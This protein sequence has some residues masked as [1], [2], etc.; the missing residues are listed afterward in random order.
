LPKERA[1]GITQMQHGNTAIW[2]SPTPAGERPEFGTTIIPDHPGYLAPSPGALHREFE[3]ALAE[4]ERGRGREPRRSGYAGQSQEAVFEAGL[5]ALTS[6]LRAIFQEFHRDNPDAISFP[7]EIIPEM[8]VVASSPGS[9]K[10]TSAKAFML[11]VV[12]EGLEDKYPLG[13]AFVVQHVETAA[14]AYEELKPLLPG[15]VAVWTLEHDADSPVT[16]REPRFTVSELQDYP[17]IIVT[18]EF[19]KGVRAEKARSYRRKGMS[20]P[21]VVTFVDEKVEQVRV[22]DIKFSDIVKVRE[23]LE[24]ADDGT[25]SLKDALRTLDSFAGKKRNET[26]KLE[27]PKDD[28][29]GWSVARELIWFTT[30]EARQYARSRS[31]A[32]Q[33]TRKSPPNIEGV[34]GFAR[35]MSENRAFIARQGQG[36]K[37]AVFVG[38]EQVLPDYRGMVLLD[39]TADIDGLNELCP[40]RRPVKIPQATYERLEIVYVPSVAD[41]T[42]KRWL[43]TN[44]NRRDYVRHILETVRSQVAP[45]QKAL[46]VCKLDIVDARP[47]IEG[48]SANVKPFLTTSNREFS[49][50]FEGRLLSLTWWG[51]YGVGANHWKEA[52]V[53]LLFDDFHLPRHA[54]I[55]ITQGVKR[56]LATQAPLSDMTAPNSIPEEVRKIRDGHLLRW[57][58]QMALRGRSREF[59][60]TGACGAQKLVVTGDLKLLMANFHRVFPGLHRVFPG[61]KLSSGDSKATILE[62]L[63]RYLSTAGLPSRVSTKQIGDH[64]QRPWRSIAG[65]ITRHRDFDT[66][67]RNVGW[68][69]VSQR[70]KKGAY[71]ERIEDALPTEEELQMY[72]RRLIELIRRQTL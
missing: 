3:T 1:K 64:F 30:E 10:S 31:A 34:F 58:K 44:E 16:K 17:I 6:S 48:W 37:G 66:L 32:L 56:A 12:R 46:L 61:A 62:R 51:G 8:Q 47:E 50:E 57:I 52:D 27:T 4:L 65:D 40:W 55:A 5:S 67:L 7:N 49:W 36:E 23:H 59:D 9:G 19:F 54:T 25:A 42:L 29:S 41:G 13:C 18:H 14:T 39:A 2:R 53:V 20:F 38:Y 68:S 28:E 24:E 22:H 63:L 70:G 26:R 33:N 71:F 45:G 72:R 15:Q 43:Q 21:R 69:Y 11:A 60:G 35:C